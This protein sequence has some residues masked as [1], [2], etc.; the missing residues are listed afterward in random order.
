MRSRKKEKVYGR[1]QK[2]VP[3]SPGA[4]PILIL[5]AF[6]VI[7]AA[8]V[9]LL[10]S[11]SGGEANKNDLGAGETII[12]IS[13]APVSGASGPGWTWSGVTYT[14]SNGA[15][16]KVIQSDPLTVPNRRLTTNPGATV[17]ITLSNVNFGST[18]GS[19]IGT[20]TGSTVNLFLEGMNTLRGG[21]YTPS[22][23][24]GDYRYPAIYTTG[25]ALIIKEGDVPGTLNAYGAPG[26]AGIGGMYE[27]IVG[28]PGASYGT[29]GGNVTIDGGTVNAYGGDGSDRGGGAGIGGAGGAVGA[30]GGNGGTVTINGGTVNAYGGRA[31]SLGGGAGAGIGGG[32]GG[33][34]YKQISVPH[35]GG[36][37]A[38]VIIEGGVV[39]AT[40]GG[41]D[42]TSG[43]AAAG[44]GGGGGGN[45]GTGPG[46]VSGKGGA[47][48]SL[49]VS[50]GSVTAAGS[51]GS[52][53]AAGIGAGNGGTGTGNES[54]GANGTFILNGNGVVTTAG[55]HSD[56]TLTNGILMNTS[57]LSTVPPA[58]T[59]LMY[60]SS[61]T[62]TDDF[63][64]PSGIVLNLTQGKTLTVQE[65]VTMTNEGTV[66]GPMALVIEEGATLVNDG[67]INYSNGAGTA[68]GSVI[69]DFDDIGKVINNGTIVPG[70]E[71]MLTHPPKTEYDAFD[72]IDLTEAEFEWVIIDSEGTPIVR[73]FHNHGEIEVTYQN[74]DD[75]FRGEDD[76]VTLTVGGSSII[77][78]TVTVTINKIKLPLPALTTYTF[79]YD[80]GVKDPI[81]IYDTDLSYIDPSSIQT[82]KNAGSYSV[83]I[84][85]KDSVN[86]EWDRASDKTGPA[87]LAW[88]IAKATPNV[89]PPAIGT[90]TY[91]P[92]KKLSS[93]PLPPGWTWNDPNELIGNVGDKDFPATYTNISDP[94]NYEQAGADIGFIYAKAWVPLPQ[95]A[96]TAFKYTA[97]PQ[98]PTVTLPASVRFG[99]GSTSSEKDVGDYS[100][101]LSLNDPENYEWI[102][103]ST[104]DVRIPW[105]ISKAVLKVKADDQMKFYDADNPSLTYTI[106]GFLGSDDEAAAITGSF[107]ISTEADKDS[108]IG[109]YDIIIEQGTASSANYDI[110]FENGTLTVT[111]EP[112]LAVPT[113]TINEFLYNGGLRRPRINNFIDG[114][115][116]INTANSETSGRNAG[117]YYI[118]IQLEE[119]YKWADGTVGDVVLRWDILK[120]PVMAMADDTSKIYGTENPEFSITYTGFFSTDNISVFLNPASAS[121]AADEYSDAGTYSINVDI[122]GCTSQNYYMIHQNGTLTVQKAKLNRPA[123]D[124][125]VFIY[126]GEERTPLF[127]G[128]DGTLMNVKAE[129]TV[130]ATSAGTYT[131]TVEITDKTNYTWET[132]GTDDVVFT[133]TI[134]K[135][136]VT[137]KADDKTKE[138]G[139]GNPG[140]TLTYSGLIGSDSGSVFSSSPVPSTSANILSSA[141]TYPITV[142]VS[143]VTAANYNIAAENGTL[144]ITRKQISPDPE[145]DTIQ[146]FAY[147]AEIQRPIISGYDHTVMTV[148]PSSTEAAVNAGDYT[149]LISLIDTHNYEWIDGT[150]LP[151]TMEWKITKAMLTVKADNLSREYGTADPTLTYSATGFMG[152]DTLSSVTG[153]FSLTT[154]ALIGSP[155]MRDGDSYLGY[156]ITI[157]IGT[158]GS[159]NYDFTFINGELTVTPALVSLPWMIAFGVIYDGT[160]QEPFLFTGRGSAAVSGD[161]SATDAGDYTITV[162][163]LDPLNTQWVNGK[164]DDIDLEWSIAK[165]NLMIMADYYY[166]MGDILRSAIPFGYTVIAGELYGSDTES[167]IGLGNVT[168]TLID[169][170]TDAVF[171]GDLVTMGTY[172]IRMTMAGDPSDYRNYNLMMVDGLLMIFQGIISFEAETPTL[173]NGVYSFEYTG[174]PQAVL[175]VFDQSLV[176]IADGSETL[177]TDVGEY[178][179]NFELKFPDLGDT[180]AEDGTNGSKTITWYI[181]PAPL[182]VTAND[183]SRPYNTANPETFG[184]KIEGFK[185]N[186]D[187]GVISG[188]F[189]VTTT[190]VT[191]SPHIES[192]GY[193][194]TVTIG[195]AGADNYTFTFADGTLYVLKITN[196]VPRFSVP[197]SEYST[198]TVDF[199][200]YL[201]NFVDADMEIFDPEMNVI[202]PST[203]LKASDAGVYTVI[204]KL[205]DHIDYSWPDGTSDDL[206]LT[207]TISKAPL[208]VTA[209]DKER[210]YNVA[211]PELTADVTGLKGSDTMI[212]LSLTTNAMITSVPGPYT[213]YVSAGTANIANYD[214]TFVNGTLNILKA[215]P[216]GAVPGVSPPSASGEHDYGTTLDEWTLTPGWEWS[217][218]K[219]IP[220][221]GNE[222]LEAV[223]DVSGWDVRY[224]Y[225]D[226]DGYDPVTHTVKQKPHVTVNRL[227]LTIKADDKSKTYGETDP[228]FTEHFEGSARPVPG[229]EGMY[230]VTFTIYNQFRTV[231]EKG[232]TLSAGHYAIVPTVVWSNPNYVLIAEDGEYTV[233]KAKPADF[234]P[235]AYGAYEYGTEL[236]VW[237]LTPGWHWYDGTMVPTLGNKTG[238]LA[239]M[240]ADYENY[241]YSGVADFDPITETISRYV[242]VTILKLPFVTPDPKPKDPHH[243]DAPLDEWELNDGW[244][245]EDGS[246]VPKHGNHGYV[247]ILDVS[248]YEDDYDLSGI[249][250]YDP[251]THT[252][253]R[254]VTISIP[255]GDIG[256]EWG[257]AALIGA[258]L[259]LM[260]AGALLSRPVITV[261]ITYRGR[262]VSGAAVEYSV[263]GEY[264]AEAVT[265]TE[266][267]FVIKVP[268][269]TEIIITSIV[270]DGKGVTEKMPISL[271]VERDLKIEL[272]ER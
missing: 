233:N 170:E 253:T 70:R 229:D 44:I 203:D 158:A 116:S 122:S 206:V 104:A 29:S 36:N 149:V 176:V 251:V 256:T 185:N 45:V 49:N 71:L 63:V 112:T 80:G 175:P 186:E 134:A 132:G 69:G 67:L 133:W 189:D 181:T 252:I 246:T 97:E 183:V 245:W 163:L 113:L 84:L 248:D 74:A 10:P 247:V 192:G 263:G 129:S 39:S 91:E 154:T 17:T 94:D 54:L 43:G 50:G 148:V 59:G 19:A 209:D 48:G 16:V 221:Y 87:V 8:I 32:G 179:I 196:D 215:K 226:V 30:G 223:I 89:T 166:N 3:H 243:E 235:I 259:L 155:V 180:W 225:S 28:N 31:G 242:P 47:G 237:T 123:L 268:D 187:V 115:M 165:S 125:Y 27:N 222:G 40:A 4:A 150:I 244:K 55:F 108:E 90:V 137:V 110:T 184:V 191:S 79:T 119:G 164:T 99:D 224:D 234:E 220:E 114:K 258:A 65:N 64:I 260:I 160:E 15:N 169:F 103:G 174:L 42:S 75:G 83:T 88:S 173:V 157:T 267:S 131:I 168:Y 254:T 5:A 37:G 95:V 98:G 202:D 128:F 144:T 151:R 250:G 190:A 130:S 261:K 25:S 82:A 76:H 106:T 135:A 141:G 101:V 86:Y 217:F 210:E 230:T 264:S 121:S 152:G 143:G 153:Q 20:G 269:G 53:A 193:P 56:N 120:A 51:N 73:P 124:N 38:F 58:G 18:Q 140:L 12:D 146:S 127:T 195:S 161:T 78:G 126:D 26:A 172:Y 265:D 147:N 102:G 205:K 33:V 93:I 118:T 194:I 117:D 271:F 34:G 211:N 239:V 240:S 41:I 171:T 167:S 2:A 1:S 14:L 232:L 212:G 13:A 68:T 136:L 9:L 66:T 200:Q 236:S 96:P 46:S 100:V 266:G 138:Y 72:Q 85:L 23:G 207:Y 177:G 11:D 139:T 257:L 159:Q 162:G 60:G 231:V 216:S 22:D 238:Y 197:G 6:I 62:P 201:E 81:P 272:S 7:A 227:V 262:P 218:P 61:V 24:S 241:D 219:D 92:D 21:Q 198:E 111:E 199:G 145:W 182:T 35:T 105:S 228:L 249:P 178:T 208:T 213:I 214:V 156:P 142:N 204:I 57:S 52:S 77:N 109:T 107:A 188:W 270:A 255:A